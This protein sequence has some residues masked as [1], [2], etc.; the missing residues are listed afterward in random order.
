MNK[1]SAAKLQVRLVSRIA[2]REAVDLLR[3][4]R[5]AIVAA[6][7]LLLL[8]VSAWIGAQ[9]YFADQKQQ[10]TLVQGERE[11]WLTQGDRHPH[12]AAHQGF[13]VFKPTTILSVADPGITTHAGAA[14]HLEPHRQRLFRY[15][16]AE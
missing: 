4:R 5:L 8:S 7:V 9:R 2:H 14:V 10:E 6:S 16:P 1:V 11:R 12:S 13:W 15:S 3:D